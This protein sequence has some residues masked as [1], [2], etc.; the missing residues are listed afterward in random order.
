[1]RVDIHV[2]D[3]ERELH[4]TETAP[5]SGDPQPFTAL[6]QVL[7][8]AT[9]RLKAAAD[10]GGRPAG[11]PDPLAALRAPLH[12][13]GTSGVVLDLDSPTV[14]VL[15]EVDLERHR[16]DQRWGE[17]NH[18]DG[19]SAQNRQK[20]AAA[21]ATC[22]RKAAAGLV[23]WRD[24]LLEEV[25]EAG[26]EEDPDALREELLQVAAVAVAWIEAIDRRPRS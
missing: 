6:E 2:Q 22:E 24:I 18:P 10:P 15:Q 26:A 14:A 13:V 8:V 21:K 4:V 1:M 11:Y 3:A 20:A 19:T 25:H 16:Q 5:P 17:Q 12:A 9:T 23:S 7:E